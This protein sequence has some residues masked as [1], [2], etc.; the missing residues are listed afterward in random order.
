MTEYAQSS[1]AVFAPRLIFEIDSVTWIEADIAKAI[2]V[3][4]SFVAENMYVVAVVVVA[5][6]VVAVV[7]MT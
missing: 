5:V 3:D 7:V 4:T 2:A 6:V 1:D